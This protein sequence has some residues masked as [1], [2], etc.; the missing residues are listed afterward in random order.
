MIEVVVLA[1]VLVGLTAFVAAPLYS[2]TPQERS[3]SSGRR[4]R[5]E[6]LTRDLGELEVDLASGLLDGPGY[7]EERAELERRREGSVATPD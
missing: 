6:A 5:D 1:V 7:T 3:P 2:A 4:A